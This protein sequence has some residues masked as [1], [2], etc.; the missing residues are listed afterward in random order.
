MK[1]IQYLLNI[2]KKLQRF[3]Q[4][5]DDF[6]ELCKDNSIDIKQLQSYN[7][8]EFNAYYDNICSSDKDATENIT[9]CYLYQLIMTI[10]IFTMK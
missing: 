1:L 7:D 4:I 9:S 10:Q 2:E 6:I 8:I 3:I 5:S